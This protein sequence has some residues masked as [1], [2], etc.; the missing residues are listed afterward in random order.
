MTSHKEMTNTY[1][2]QNNSEQ[3]HTI[4]TTFL[5]SSYANKMHTKIQI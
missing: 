2:L 3:L 5:N 4:C 1:S